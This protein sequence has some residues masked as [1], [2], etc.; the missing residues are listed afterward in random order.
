MIGKGATV[1]SGG[2][3][4]STNAAG[5]SLVLAPAREDGYAVRG[6]MIQGVR[7]YDSNT[8][9]WTTPDAY[10][11]DVH[12][13]MSQRSYMWNNNNPVAYADPS[14]YNP[15]VSTTAN[16]D[17]STTVTITFHVV[18]KDDPGVSAADE[19]RFLDNLKSFSEDD[20][21]YHVVV[22]AVASTL[23]EYENQ[24]VVHL[25][26]SSNWSGHDGGAPANGARGND[27]HALDGCCDVRVGTNY[28]SDA[29][30]RYG[31]GHEMF[32]NAM[33]GSMGDHVS[34]ATGDVMGAWDGRVRRYR[35]GTYNASFSSIPRRRNEDRFLKRKTR[36]RLAAALLIA[37]L[38]S[39][40]SPVRAATDLQPGPRSGTATSRATT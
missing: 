37:T 11:G 25:E 14:G 24:T 21:K 35:R 33:E 13:P 5:D 9:Q 20:G 12:D 1:Q 38:F 39:I 36:V 6:L 23:N 7:S 10:K 27:S 2:W 40:V 16:S 30:T 3:V 31:Q 32:H 4:G 15:D 22:N 8:E 18:F 34:G 26:N 19:K 29:Q 28:G 17:G